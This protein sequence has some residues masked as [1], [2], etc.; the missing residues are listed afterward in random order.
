MP[1]VGDTPAVLTP[2]FPEP[3]PRAYGQGLG[4]GQAVA[5][6]RTLARVFR[7][8]LSEECERQT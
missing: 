6:A 3:F 7:V 5:G 8:L 2:G 4:T 1:A